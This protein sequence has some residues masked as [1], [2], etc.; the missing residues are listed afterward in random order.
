MTKRLLVLS[1]VL[2][3]FCPPS[4]AQAPPP[5]A[6]ALASLASLM[7]SFLLANL[8]PVLLEDNHN[9][10]K[11]SM[12]F[13][14]LHWKGK[15]LRVQPRVEKAAKN[16]GH[17][18]K[19]RISTRNLPTTLEFKLHNLRSVAPDRATFAAYLAFQ[20]TVEV[21]QQIWE[22]GVRLFSGRTQARLRLQLPMECEAT[23][24]LEEGKT[25]IP[26]L[27]CRL[28]VLKADLSY[29]QLVV[30]HTA[31][32]GGDGARVLG[33]LLHGIVK[34]VKPSLERDLFHRAN[35]AIVKAADTR[36]VRLG[37]GSLLK[38]PKK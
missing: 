34:G 1:F 3:V 2:L 35:V 15:G 23:F 9:W 19:V 32:I 20:A 30:E 5:D 6:A 21:E 4:A 36:E 12:V 18:K 29:H 27:V 13:H 10:G 17:W 37:L 7:K 26:D 8:P 14:A 24:R 16:D 25:F 38:T 28:R 31:G 33:D 11:T 22:S